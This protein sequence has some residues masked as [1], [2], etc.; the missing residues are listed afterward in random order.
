MGWNA[1]SGPALVIRQS[2]AIVP[3]VAGEVIDVPVMA[4]TPLKANDVLFRIDPTT[5]QAQ[6]DQLA[7]QLKFQ[8]LRLSQMTQLQRTGSGRAF[9]VQERQAEVDKLRAQL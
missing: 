4:N 2:V 6:V 8:E 7:S 9:D 5:Y 3:D 1:P